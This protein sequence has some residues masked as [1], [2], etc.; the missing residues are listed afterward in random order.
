[1][2][3]VCSV[4]WLYHY[5]FHQEPIIQ[6]VSIAFVFFQLD[7]MLILHP[8]EYT[9]RQFMVLPFSLFKPMHHLLAG[10]LIAI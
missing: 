3:E 6:V 9:Q 2:A 1:M 7:C 5:S 4:M 8:Y 10:H